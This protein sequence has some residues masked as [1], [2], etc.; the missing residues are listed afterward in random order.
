MIN[1]IEKSWQSIVSDISR[2]PEGGSAVIALNG[3]TVVP[4]EV[5]RAIS[6]VKVR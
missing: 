2:L 6:D 5:V 1:G 3:E 4:V